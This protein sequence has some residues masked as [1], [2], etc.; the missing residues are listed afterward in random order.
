MS[1]REFLQRVA[2]GTAA[3]A[4]ESHAHAAP[5]RKRPNVLYVFSDQHRAVSM[6]D[7]AHSPVIAPALAAFKRQGLSMERCISNYPLCTPYRAML[8]SGRWPYQTGVI[9]NNIAL[10]PGQVSL[11]S[12]F[13]Q[14]GY[15][16]GYVGKWHLQGRGIRFVPAGPARHGFADWRVWVNTNAHFHSWS[17]DQL[18]GARIDA[19]G[20]SCARMSDD[21]LDFIHAQ[22]RDR[23]W[24]LML[25][26][27]PPHPPFNAVRADV[28]RY[29]AEAL[30]LR[31]NV[32]LPP[33]ASRG[34]AE[35]RLLESEH[36]LR[37]A[38]QGYYGAISGV[39]GQFARLLQALEES[40][41]AEDTIVIYTSDH[42]EMMGSQGRMAKQV[43]FE[44]AVRVPFLLR[45]PGVTRPGEQSSLLFSA[46]DIYPSLCGLAGLPVP[47]FCV[48]RDLSP[49]MRGESVEA[50]AYAF[51]MNQSGDDVEDGRQAGDRWPDQAAPSSDVAADAKFVAQPKYRGVRTATHTYAVAL[52]G[53]WCLYDNVNDP[54]QMNNL[55][56]DPH[57]LALMMRLDAAIA[58][59]LDRGGDPFPYAQAVQRFADF[60]V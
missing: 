22:P 15:H 43:P 48:G 32:A 13:Q 38:M 1:R 11:G 3:L 44:E 2:L 39:D 12:W 41:Q 34:G 49:A 17:Y 7:Q 42:G 60:P 55:V 59:W 58:D 33:P 57:Q 5:R 23:P 31:P 19:T 36:T 40:G 35:S 9:A 26:L 18:S 56:R 30:P 6:P 47:A 4:A 8:M 37:L 29:Q 20:W 14:H 52:A 21:A 25:S 50:P 53:R 16:T 28:E 27:N 54:Y 46:V 45:Y 51:L 10:D 24:F